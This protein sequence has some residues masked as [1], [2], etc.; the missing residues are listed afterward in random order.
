LQI[1]ENVQAV[2]SAVQGRGRMDVRRL[3]EGTKKL[4]R[5]EGKKRKKAEDN[6]GQGRLIDQL[7]HDITRINDYRHILANCEKLTL[8][9]DVVPTRL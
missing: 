7:L 4:R 9:R 8:V 3:G 2:Q 1:P 5:A 6:K